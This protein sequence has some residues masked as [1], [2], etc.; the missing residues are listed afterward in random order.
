MSEL[1]T[2]DNLPLTVVNK[3]RT[4]VHKVAN[5]CLS[6]GRTKEELM[7]AGVLAIKPKV[8]VK[9]QNCSTKEIPTLPSHLKLVVE[10]QIQKKHVLKTSR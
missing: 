7:L 3:F 2:K 8:T 10:T 9:K 5:D 6:R 4:K 1:F